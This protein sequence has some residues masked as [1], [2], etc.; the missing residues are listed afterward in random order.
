MRQSAD[1]FRR[2]ILL[3][4]ALVPLC[5]AATIEASVGAGT[6]ATAGNHADHG[7]FLLATGLTSAAICDSAAEADLGA[8]VTASACTNV[9]GGEV[10][11]FVHGYAA[12]SAPHDEAT[13]AHG[14]VNSIGFW[15]DLIHIDGAGPQVFDLT[16]SLSFAYDVT[17][18]ADPLRFVAALHATWQLGMYSDLV[19]IAS[20][21]S[22]H[23]L[24][25]YSRTQRV[26]LEGGKSYGLGLNLQIGST[27]GEFLTGGQKYDMTLDAAHSTAVH[28]DPVTPGA[29]YTSDS[30]ISYLT[31][32]AVPE[33][34]VW[35]LTNFAIVAFSLLCRKI[36]RR[37][38]GRESEGA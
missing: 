3:M 4:A 8:T 11:D 2:L 15:T 19:D 33:P 23:S 12:S 28:L 34:A 25:T 1:D 18:P 27:F 20:P 38:D 35:P 26:T 5:R 17:G 13:A 7:H 22:S 32:T 29:S 24:Q 36:L 6:A 21:E 10:K 30:G 37:M 16:S 31:N 9:S 14:E